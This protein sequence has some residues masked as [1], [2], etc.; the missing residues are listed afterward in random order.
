[1]KAFGHDVKHIDN[2]KILFSNSFTIYSLPF[3][4]GAA[5]LQSES[6]DLVFTSPPFFDY[7]MYSDNNPKYRDWINDFYKPLF[8]ESCRCVKRGKHV[9][10]HIG[11]TSA[12]NIESFLKEEVHKICDLKLV[13]KIG[14]SVHALHAHAYEWEVLVIC[15]Y[16]RCCRVTACLLAVV[17]LLAHVV[18]YHIVIIIR[19]DR[20]EV[21]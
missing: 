5:Q 6:F 12:G 16:N 17:D 9:A 4:V 21:E 2:E 15:Y 1:M 20:N 8:I 11:D 19:P 14:E 7:E 18:Q 10:I 13:F 3:E